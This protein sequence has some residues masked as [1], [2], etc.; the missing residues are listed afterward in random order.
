MLPFMEFSNNII[1]IYSDDKDFSWQ[2]A[3][4]IFL[5]NRL[6]KPVILDFSF[7]TFTNPISTYWW[8]KYKIWFKENI[9]IKTLPKY[10]DVYLAKVKKELV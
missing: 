10:T 3:S 2:P 6:R 1:H 8:F 7:I 5:M 9:D 4:D